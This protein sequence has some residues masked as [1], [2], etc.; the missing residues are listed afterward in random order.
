MQAENLQA[1]GFNVLSELKHLRERLDEVAES[2]LVR[3]APK[4]LWVH[5]LP[6]TLCPHGTQDSVAAKG[7]IFVLVE[8]QERRVVALEQLHD[9]LQDGLRAVVEQANLPWSELHLVD[10]EGGSHSSSHSDDDDDAS[11]GESDAASTDPDDLLSPEDEA[12]G[13]AGSRDGGG[14]GV[15]ALREELHRLQLE[16]PEEGQLRQLGA[17]QMEL[18]REMAKLNSEEEALV[19]DAALPMDVKQEEF[20]SLQVCRPRPVRTNALAG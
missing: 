7:D 15:D 6:V 9:E 5:L 17:D 12:A 18:R 2:N 14:G 10:T 13:T 11:E 3:G 20:R 19:S 16:T 4:R 8:S 1:R